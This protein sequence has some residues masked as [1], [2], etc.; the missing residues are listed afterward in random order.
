MLE[1]NS[2]Q[3]NQKYFYMREFATFRPLIQTMADY[4]KRS[5]VVGTGKGVKGRKRN[6]SRMK[7]IMSPLPLRNLL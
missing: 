3:Q 5:K 7:R 1:T 4:T 6:K 2:R